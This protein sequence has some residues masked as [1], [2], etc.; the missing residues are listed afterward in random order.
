MHDR[1]IF[2]ALC[3]SAALLV[4]PAVNGE[5][6]QAVDQYGFGQRAFLIQSALESGKSANGLWDVPGKPG[7][8]GTSSMTR[9]R[10]GRTW[11]YGSGRRAIRKTVCSPSALRRERRGQ[12]FYQIRPRLS[13][14]CERDRNDREDRGALPRRPFRAEE[15]RRDRWKIYYKPDVIVCLEKPTAKNGTKL[16]LRPDH[17]GAHTEWV[18]STPPRRNRSSPSRPRW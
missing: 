18:F 6:Q 11:A 3:F 13:L 8:A 5:A 12:V 2:S 10:T 7:E 9:R 4:F 15:R 16:V 14:G 17:S 1:K